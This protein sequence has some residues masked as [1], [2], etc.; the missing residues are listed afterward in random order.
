[1]TII[2]AIVI[3]FLFGFVLF[4]IGAADPDK[5]VGMLC[6]RDLHLMKTIFTGIG[7]ASILLFVG[8]VTGAIA[9]GHISVKTMYWGVIPGGLLLGLGW[10]MAGF[11]PGTGVVAA[12]SGRKDAWVF[13]LGG[14]V[15]AALYMLAYEGVHAT[16]ILKPIWGGN[17]TLVAT[18]KSAAWIDQSWSPV[19]AILMGAAMIGVAKI[20]PDGKS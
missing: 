4:K 13:V 18:G 9:V 5:I 17:A 19:L 8:L 1:M 15:G 6:L 16:G 11:C 3:G 10:A 20:I 14:L 12:G 7:V 2:L